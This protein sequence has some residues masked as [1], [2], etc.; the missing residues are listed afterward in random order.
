MINHVLPRMAC[1]CAIFAIALAHCGCQSLKAPAGWSSASKPP[2][3]PNNKEVVTYWGQKKPKG[4]APDMDEL[5]NRMA[6]AQDGTRATTFEGHLR[7]GNQALGANRLEDAQREYEKALAMRPN[8]PDCHHRLAVVADKQRKFG[9]ADDHYEAALKVR[10]RDPNLLSDY[11]YSFSLRGGEDQRAEATLNEALAISPSHKGAMANL[12]AIYAKQGRYEE[13]LAMFRRGG[14]ETEAQHYMAQLFP[15]RSH[16]AE[17]FAQNGN[18]NAPRSAPPM[19]EERPDLRGMSADQLKALMNREKS[20]AIQ[21]RQ[22][23]LIAEGQRPRTDWTNEDAQRQAMAAQQQQQPSDPNRQN[24]PIVLGPGSNQV[25]TNP[26]S[27]QWPVVIPDGGQPINQ[28]AGVNQAMNSQAQGTAA[29]GFGNPAM[30][31]S[32]RAQPGTSP[33]IDVWGG[34]DIQTVGGTQPQLQ[35]SANPYGSPNAGPAMQQPYGTMAP[36]TGQSPLAGLDLQRSGGTAGANPGALDINA[37]LAAAQ[38]GMNVGPGGMFPLVPPDLSNQPGI[39]GPNGWDTRPSTEFSSPSQFQLPPGQPLPGR[40]AMT[41]GDPRQGAAQGV[42][43]GDSRAATNPSRASFADFSNQESLGPQSPASNWPQI[44][45]G[46]EVVQA[47]AMAPANAATPRFNDPTA[48]N[49]NDQNAAW[50]EKPNLN[51]AAPF[52][53][54][55]PPGSQAPAAP[56][57]N[58]SN[59]GSPN[60]LPMWNGG[61]P[62]SRPQPKQFGQ[63][64]ANS[65]DYY[66]ERWPG[67]PR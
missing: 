67:A 20:D 32:L 38:L 63:S 15:Q 23:Q 27:N 37:S 33:K 1:S 17:A 10:P 36:N 53:G 65:S 22:Q 44:N 39:S 46:Q 6:T 60:S 45:A 7:Q 47:G 8:D 2:A 48:R 25:A 28:G 43:W 50:A 31:G 13:A 26:Q 35:N 49:L 58:A 54:A 40:S 11:G 9:L 12:G 16:A 52:N 24:S 21:R 18:T 41:P 34:A 61:Q 14:S 55:W 51:S 66:P 3:N 59:A 19:P 29:N 57:G 42:N 62:A 56:G 5:K 30:E 64:A 4:K